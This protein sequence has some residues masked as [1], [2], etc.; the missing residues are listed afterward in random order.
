MFFSMGPLLLSLL[1]PETLSWIGFVV[2]ISAMLGEVAVNLIPA[3]RRAFHVAAAFGFAALAVAG[4]SIERVGDD[5]ITE[6]LKNRATSAESA[7]VKLKAPRTLVPERQEFVARA[8]KLFGGQRYRASVSQGADDGVAF[9]ESLYL[10]LDRAGWVYVTAPNISVG[11]PP[12]GV[13]IAAI[14][15]V[16]IRFDPAKEREMTPAALAL[17]NALHA[18]GTVVSVNRDRQ[19]NPDETERDILNIVIGARVPPR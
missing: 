5:A 1:P 11:N 12:A 9:W 15:G 16:E 3:R 7:L 8:I 2:L 10:A 18:D 6:A 17:G 19:S 13:P 14:P 4:Y